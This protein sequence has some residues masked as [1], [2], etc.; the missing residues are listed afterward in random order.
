MPLVV[1]H[2]PGDDDV[3]FLRIVLTEQLRPVAALSVVPWSL[4]GSSGL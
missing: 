4:F 3:R 1:E 2:L